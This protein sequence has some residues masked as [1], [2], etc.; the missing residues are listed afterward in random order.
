MSSEMSFHDCLSGLTGDR[1]ARE[2]FRS[3]A[4]RLVGL[5]RLRLDARLRGKEDPEDVVQ[6]VFRTFFRRHSEGQFRFDDWDDLWTVLALI[7]SRKCINRVAHFRAQRR[8][9]RK[10]LDAEED[11][12]GWQ[13]L[14]R[15]P[16]PEE[17]VLLEEAVTH[18]LGQLGE[19]ERAIVVLALD[20]Y[21]VA[22]IAERLGRTNRT[23]QRVLKCVR[24]SLQET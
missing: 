23:V 3:F 6:S 17:A 1:A 15:E 13:A 24:E 2:I 5:A 18:L 22:E 10:E 19:R 8:D 21:S 16:T 11:A 14:A 4:V 12:S 7:T 20:G 9:F